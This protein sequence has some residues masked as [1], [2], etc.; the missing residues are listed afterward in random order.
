MKSKIVEAEHLV[1]AK[2]SAFEAHRSD[3]LLQDLNLAKVALH[4]WL[5]AE[6]VHW[7]QRAKIN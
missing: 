4:N 1:M 2:R 6:A 3:P 7:K 5:N